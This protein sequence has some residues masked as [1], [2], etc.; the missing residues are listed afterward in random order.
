MKFNLI[1]YLLSFVGVKPKTYGLTTDSKVVLKDLP[2]KYPTKDM[3]FCRFNKQIG[4][5]E[6]KKVDI[7]KKEVTL[8]E[9]GTDHEI[10]VSFTI[11]NY[12]FK[13]Y[14]TANYLNS[15]KNTA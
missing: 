13:D 6:V 15:D 1:R 2:E 14:Y 7:K 10:V 3:T 8:N 11:Y 12:L 9:L 4:V 5:F